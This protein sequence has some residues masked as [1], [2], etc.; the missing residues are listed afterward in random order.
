[1]TKSLTTLDSAERPVLSPDGMMINR[2]LYMNYIGDFIDLNGPNRRELL[3]SEGFRLPL[4]RFK[5]P[6]EIRKLGVHMKMASILGSSNISFS[7]SQK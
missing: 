4:K 5:W 1:M 3:H 6:L 2:E 7:F